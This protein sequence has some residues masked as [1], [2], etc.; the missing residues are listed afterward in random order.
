MADGEFQRGYQ[1]ALADAV[2]TMNIYMNVI[3]RIPDGTSNNG[4]N[5]VV[6]RA[7]EMARESVRT[8]EPGFLGAGN[9]KAA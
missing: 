3:E 8:L 4:V 7:L 9:D 5:A 1:Q 6:I 2:E